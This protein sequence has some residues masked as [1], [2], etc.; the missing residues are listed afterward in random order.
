M[1]MMDEAKTNGTKA[2]KMIA[3]FLETG[4]AGGGGSGG[5]GGKKKKK[6][7]ITGGASRSQSAGALDTT[8]QLGP[9]PSAPSLEKR[10][11]AQ[12]S[13]GE[14]GGDVRPYVSPYDTADMGAEE[15]A[16]ATVTF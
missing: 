10:L 13:A 6:K 4:D 16:P 5:G 2:T 14:P 11:E 9:K 3:S 12:A 1:H 7:A 15:A 8:N